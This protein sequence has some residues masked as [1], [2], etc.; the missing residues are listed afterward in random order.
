MYHVQLHRQLQ[1]RPEIDLTDQKLGYASC[2]GYKSRLKIS[3]SPVPRQGSRAAAAFWCRLGYQEMPFLQPLSCPTTA[4]SR[5][6]K[7]LQAWEIT[8]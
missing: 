2:V 3:L 4:L 7:G 6:T 8:L 5:P 1:Y